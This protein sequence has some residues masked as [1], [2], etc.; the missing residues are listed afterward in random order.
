MALVTSAISDQEQTLFSTDIVKYQYQN[1]DPAN[2][3]NGSFSNLALK[4]WLQVTIPLT[5]LTLFGA[6]STYRFYS[7]S[8]RDVTFFERSKRAVLNTAPL[9]AGSYVQAPP[10]GS[11]NTHN[12]TDG[13]PAKRLGASISRFT[14][15]VQQFG[16][17]R[18]VLPQHEGS[19]AKSG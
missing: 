17:S 4:R 14:S 11:P 2:Y 1:Q 5:A 19:L 15:S 12:V 18:A 16:K 6:W 8:A 9:D 3:E 10:D 7:V 13:S